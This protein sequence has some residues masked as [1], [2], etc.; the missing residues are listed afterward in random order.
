MK[1]LYR[2]YSEG[3]EGEYTEGYIELSKGEYNVLIAIARELDMGSFDLE[4]IKISLDFEKI[5]KKKTGE[6][7]R[8]RKYEEE[9]E[10]DELYSSLKEKIYRKLFEEQENLDKKYEGRKDSLAYMSERMA[11]LG[12]FNQDLL[13]IDMN[14]AS[15]NLMNNFTIP[16]KNGNNDN[17]GV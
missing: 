15:R 2:L 3:V 4:E 11:M 17:R 14:Y 9:R 5:R 6:I 1:K 7:D 16:N 10:K 12:A 13:M 8:Q